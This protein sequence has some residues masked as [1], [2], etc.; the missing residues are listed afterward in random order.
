M[1]FALLGE[2]GLEEIEVFD[3]DIFGGLLFRSDAEVAHARQQRVDSP[4]VLLD[5]GGGQRF[6]ERPLLGDFAL[7]AVLGER[8]LLLQFGGEI[9]LEAGHAL[10]PTLRV[11]APAFFELAVLGRPAITALIVF[12]IMRHRSAP[13]ERPTAV[14]QHR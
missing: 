5:C 9:G 10:W 7:L 1:L 4:D 13:T 8:Q 2:I 11:A 14:E 6:D 12:G 3:V